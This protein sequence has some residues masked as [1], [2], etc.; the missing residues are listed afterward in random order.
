MYEIN[1]DF[2]TINEKR[3]NE[4]TTTLKKIERIAINIILHDFAMY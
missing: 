2:F 1:Y 3:D 4:I